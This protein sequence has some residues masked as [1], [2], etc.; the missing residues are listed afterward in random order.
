[1]KLRCY[2]KNQEGDCRE[3]RP[4]RAGQ[5]WR[6]EK[7][8]SFDE[9]LARRFPE[10]RRK[11]YHLMSIHEHLPPQARKDLK[12]AGWAKGLELAKVFRRDGQEFICA[13]WLHKLRSLPKE[14]FKR[15]AEK[16]LTGRE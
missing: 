11:A 8:K 14:E 2:A 16:D 3:E 6:P 4:I 7:L 1:M 5:Y 10:S 9:F 12:E 13:A 15:K